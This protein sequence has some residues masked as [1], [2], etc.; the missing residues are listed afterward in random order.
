[1]VLT[2]KIQFSQAIC[3]FLLAGVEKIQSKIN[4]CLALNSKMLR[5]KFETLFSALVI[6]VRRFKT[7][8]FFTSTSVHK[9][10]TFLFLFRKYICRSTSAK[11]ADK[12]FPQ[13]RIF[14]DRELRTKKSAGVK[15]LINYFTHIYYTIFSLRTRNSYVSTLCTY[16]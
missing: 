15:K 13:Q 8:V 4:F 5:V 1:M 6:K 2:S 14:Q 16:M 7:S 3:E 12:W 9:P 10:S 11:P